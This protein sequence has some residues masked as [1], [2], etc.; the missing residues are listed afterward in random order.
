M[1]GFVPSTSVAQGL[2]S[3]DPG[4]GHGPSRQAMLSQCP[5]WQSQK[6]LQLEYTLC[7]WGFGEEKK[8]KKKED[9]QQILA[10]G[11]IF[12]K[13]NSTVSQGAILTRSREETIH[14]S[15]FY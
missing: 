12:K 1:I 6:D 2:A 13:K 15:D 14:L 5:T 3:L 9:W 4:L 11:P 8:K 7:T 10:Q